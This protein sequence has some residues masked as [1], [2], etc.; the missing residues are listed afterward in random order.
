MMAGMTRTPCVLA[1]LALLWLS[2]T[3]ARRQ[4]PGVPAPQAD[5]QP[6]FHS[7]ANLVMLR[8]NVFDGRSDAVRQLSRDAFH[9]YEDGIEQAIEFFE[10]RDV[11]VAVGLLIDN[12]SSMLTRQAMVRAGVRAFAESSHDNDEMFTIVFNEHSRFGLPEPLGF[13]QDRDLLLS[14]LSRYPAG[15]LTALHDAVIEGLSHLAES[16]NSKRVLVV[17]S[18]GEDNA[19]RRSESDMLYRAAQSSALIYSIWTGDVSQAKGNPG[20]LKTLA[21]RTG[22]VAYAPRTERAIVEAFS[23]VAG[24]IRRGYTI[25]YTPSNTALDGSYRHIKVLLRAP[26]RKLSV[27]VREG[28]IAPDELADGAERGASRVHE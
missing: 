14:A 24:N 6:V 16:S 26:G 25:G 19:S 27:R 9:V 8:V 1:V 7:H 5:E 18:D 10:D 20:L 15:G 2:P 23:E 4:D 11:P 13:T 28:Y 22:G 17:L 21:R 3:H 12:S